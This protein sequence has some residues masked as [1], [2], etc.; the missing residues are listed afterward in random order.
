MSLLRKQERLFARICACL[1]LVLTGCASTDVSDDERPVPWNDLLLHE[2][3]C[4]GVKGI[5][6][7]TPREV[8][9]DSSGWW[10]EHLS[11][12]VGADVKDKARSDLNS[13]SVR[14]VYGDDAVNVNISFGETMHAARKG[15]PFVLAASCRGAWIELTKKFD[16]HDEWGRHRTFLVTRFAVAGD[17][18]L[19]VRQDVITKNTFLGVDSDER[20]ITW[21]RY[22]QVGQ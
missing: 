9:G 16:G 7:N 12:H 8:I 3:G 5:F 18:D 4:A 15:S 14:L 19:V 2:V 13:A 1:F 17:G 21:F 6:H 11:F 22:Q 20:K 10:T